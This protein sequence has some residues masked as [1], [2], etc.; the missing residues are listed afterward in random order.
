MKNPR[1]WG[2]LPLVRMHGAQVDLLRFTR[3]DA[4]E[5]SSEGGSESNDDDD[6]DR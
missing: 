5:G 2:S 4:Y 1:P 3:G 6:D